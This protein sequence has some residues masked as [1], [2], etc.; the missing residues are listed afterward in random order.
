[1]DL[2]LRCVLS[3]F[4][5][6][7]ILSRE[8]SAVHLSVETTDISADKLLWLSALAIRYSILSSVSLHIVFG[9]WHT[10]SSLLVEPSIIPDIWYLSTLSSLLIW[11]L[12]PGS[13]GVSGFAIELDIISSVIRRNG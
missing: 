8:S 3:G 2:V 5:H 6:A 4:L 13:A 10:S 1:M 7:Y 11:E 12:P 9:D